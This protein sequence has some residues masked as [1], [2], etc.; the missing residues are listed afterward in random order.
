MSVGP[1]QFEQWEEL[2]AH[3]HDLVLLMWS[4]NDVERVFTWGFSCGGRNVTPEIIS[5]WVRKKDWISTWL[6]GKEKDESFVKQFGKWCRFV[7]THYQ[8]LQ[9]LYLPDAAGAEEK[10]MA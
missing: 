5:S 9:W 10:N 1:A 2:A 3:V 6:W 7:L 4:N 8:R